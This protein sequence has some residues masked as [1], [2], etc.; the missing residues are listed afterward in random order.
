MRLLITLFIAIIL[1]GCKHRTVSIEPENTG[2]GPL[3]F[4]LRNITNIPVHNIT[5][6][7]YDT[8]LHIQELK[9]GAE[10]DRVNLKASYHYGYVKFTDEQ[11]RV[12]TAMPIDFVGEKLYDKGFMTFIIQTIDTAN[13]RVHMSFSTARD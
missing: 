12:Y 1:V 10:T 2:T 11:E 8:T 13:K 5:L 6:G 4:S 7:L 3:K 9:P